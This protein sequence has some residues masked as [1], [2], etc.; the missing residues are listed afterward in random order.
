MV[1]PGSDAPP[2]HHGNPGAVRRADV[3]CES[4]CFSDPRRRTCQ[5]LIGA[6]VICTAGSLI[7]AGV[8]DSSVMLDVDWRGLTA[9]SGSWKASQEDIWQHE[10]G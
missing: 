10:L 7:F 6:D 1:R 2:Q 8:L 9:S 4:S 5:E 3:C